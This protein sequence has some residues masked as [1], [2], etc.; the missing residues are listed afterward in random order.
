MI[1]MRMPRLLAI[2]LLACAPVSAAR[3]QEASR[4]FQFETRKVDA[5]FAERAGALAGALGLA[6]WPRTTE[7]YMAPAVSRSLLRRPEGVS[8]GVRSC[9]S[10]R[11]GDEAWPQC[12][13]S[14]KALAEGRKPAAEAYLDL[15]ITLAPSGRAAQEHLLSSLAD[16]QLPTEGLVALYKSARR[17]E[18]LGTV[19]F[20]IETPNGYDARL[21]FLRANVVFR[22]WG[23]GAL[24]TE[25]LPLASRLDELLLAEQPLT[26]E[27]LRERRTKALSGG[28]P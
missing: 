9:T 1:W 26:L 10:V 7:L 20:L 16:N 4:P 28:R 27:E 6:A 11:F 12:T 8:E 15:T 14:W 5:Y 18:G 3:A 19:A 22:L 13:W 17:P 24:K 2:G 25:V 21:E 23:R